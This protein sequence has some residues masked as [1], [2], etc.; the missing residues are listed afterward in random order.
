[1]STDNVA[2]QIAEGLLS[3]GA[4]ADSVNERS[5]LAIREIAPY[6]SLFRAE[7]RRRFGVRL[8]PTDLNK[9]IRELATLVDQPS[10]KA[11]SHTA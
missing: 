2:R 9:T 11:Q 4:A 7:M 10:V 3:A 6:P 1:M 5:P 8:Q